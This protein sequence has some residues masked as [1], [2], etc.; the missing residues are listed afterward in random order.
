[1]KLTKT[2]TKAAANVEM[3]YRKITIPKRLSSFELPFTRELET[4]AK[5]R[6]GATAFRVPVNKSPKIPIQANP[7]KK[8]PRKEPK[9]IPIQILEI[10]LIE[11]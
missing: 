4:S 7:G 11:L 10:R 8:N 3:M 5:T 6:T 2:A 9:T 1:M